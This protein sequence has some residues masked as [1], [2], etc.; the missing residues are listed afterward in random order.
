MFEYLKKILMPENIGQS[1]NSTSS[2]SSIS[3]YQVATAALLIEIAKADGD[4]ID[5]IL[6]DFDE[7][8]PGSMHATWD[9]IS[10]NKMPIVSGIYYYTV[11]SDYGNQIGKFVVI[12]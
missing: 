4:F 8:S 9:L 12:K 10:R 11:E 5:E 1:L 6:H 2:K 3:K 7:N